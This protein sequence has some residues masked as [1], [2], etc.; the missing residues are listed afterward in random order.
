MGPVPPCRAPRPGLRCHL[1][2]GSGRSCRHAGVGQPP[3]QVGRTGRQPGRNTFCRGGAGALGQARIGE[4]CQCS[5][6]VHSAGE[7]WNPMQAGGPAVCWLLSTAW[8]ALE[9]S[10]LGSADA[11]QQGRSSRICRSHSAPAAPCWRRTSAAGHGAAVPPPLN[12]FIEDAPAAGWASARST[13]GIMQ[14]CRPCVTWCR[15]GS[16]PLTCPFVF[17]PLIHLHLPCP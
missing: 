13:C 2:G 9:L 7:G 12:P 10:W 5:L 14:A 1:C 11:R 6:V 8:L 4:P 16:A 17:S 15:C 3:R